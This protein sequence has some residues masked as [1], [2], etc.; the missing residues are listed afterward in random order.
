MPSVLCGQSFN[1][2][3]LFQLG[4]ASVQ[5][6]RTKLHAC[7]SFDVLDEGIAVLWTTGQTGENK[8]AAI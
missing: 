7:E 2:S 6:P 3:R 4:K 5:R 8:D 1:E